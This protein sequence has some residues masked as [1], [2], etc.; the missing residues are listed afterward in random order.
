MFVR[1]ACESVE[2]LLFK[3][4]QATSVPNANPETNRII[5]ISRKDNRAQG[6]Q[7]ILCGFD[8]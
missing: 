4:N 8:P 1:E 5:S 3:T 7:A 6:M 2:N